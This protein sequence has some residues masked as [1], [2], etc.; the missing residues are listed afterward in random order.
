MIKQLN[1]FL[2]EENLTAYEFIYMTIIDNQDY[3]EMMRYYSRPEASNEVEFLNNTIDSLLD[4]GFIEEV[5]KHKDDFFNY[6]NTSKSPIHKLTKEKSK[7]EM[8][9]EQYK[10]AYPT[11]YNNMGQKRASWNMTADRGIYEL[12]EREVKT[13]E[14]FQLLMFKINSMKNANAE[15]TQNAMSFVT[16]RVWLNQDL[17]NNTLG[18]R[19]DFSI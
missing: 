15:F 10:Q 2:R 5:D 18:Q 17:D 9:V 7:I 14:M 16:S 3:T 4:K 19:N 6:R 11:Y 1:R 8:W 12:F 13:A